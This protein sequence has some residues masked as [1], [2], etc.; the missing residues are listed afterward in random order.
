VIAPDKS[1][2]IGR[3][4]ISGDLFTK[5]FPSSGGPCTCNASCCRWGVFADLR[6]RDAILA[7]REMI[8]G[9]MDDTQNRNATEWFEE[10]TIEDDDFPS[11][12]CISTR[13]H[14]DKCAFLDRE[15]R[16]S[17]Q[18]ASISKGMDKWSLKPLYCVMYPIELHA[19]I[20]N[21]DDMLQDEEHC[22]SIRTPYEIP[23]FEACKEELVHLV[24]EEGFREMQVHYRNLQETATPSL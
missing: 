20:V 15:G 21:V 10:R 11:G 19:G 3:F 4:T 2:N 18:L 8:A 22:C 16:C 1:L 9:V 12:K 23:V 7:H 24:G 14:N 6:E 13:V 5:G 17:I